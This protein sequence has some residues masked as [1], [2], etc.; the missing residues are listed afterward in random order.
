MQH[1]LVAA[2]SPCENLP[3][4]EKEKIDQNI[5]GHGAG[6]VGGWGGGGRRV[7]LISTLPCSPRRLWMLYVTGTPELATHAEK[8]KK[9]N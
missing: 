3:P 9:K 7:P 6:G 8:E 5:Q 2:E 4:S 1:C